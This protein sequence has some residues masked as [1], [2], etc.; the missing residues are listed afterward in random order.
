MN[1]LASIQR[2][3]SP[4]E[5]RFLHAAALPLVAGAFWASLYFQGV[6][7]TLYAAAFVLFAFWLG[8]ALW[9]A[10]AGHPI[11]VT[12][13]AASVAAFCL[14]LFLTLLWTRT[15]ALSALNAWWLST[16]GL[17]YFGYAFTERTGRFW[18]RLGA[19]VVTSV[20]LLC[21][22]A[23]VQAAAWGEAP[24]AMFL[25]INSFAALLNLV[26]LPLAG[27]LLARPF[28][29]RDLLLWFM[30]F[31]LVFTMFL[32]RG[33]GAFVGFALGLAVLAV[34]ARRAGRSPWGL[35]GVVGAAFAG[36]E[37]MLSGAALARL[38]T[39][40]APLAAGATRFV[41]W[42]GAWHLLWQAPWR[43]V[44]LGAFF[45]AY[46]PYRLPGDTSAGFYVHNDYLQIAIEAGLIGLFLLIGVLV[47]AT[48]TFVRGYARQSAQAVRLEAA[49]LFAGLLA[50]AV[51][52]L[53]DFNLYV[54]P[55]TLLAGLG[56]SRLDEL[57]GQ[58]RL[59][60]W[61]P[62]RFFS[63]GGLRAIIALGTVGA[64]AMASSVGL[65]QNDYRQA[66]R[67]AAEGRLV[68]ADRALGRAERRFPGLSNFWF[69]NADLL[70]HWADTLPM[71]DPARGRLAHLAWRD[72]AR[73]Q[74]L[75]PWQ[76][77]TFLIRA[78]LL[79]QERV[80]L[81]PGA[82]RAAL[83]AVYQALARDPRFYPARLFGARL[84][85]ASHQKLAAR[86]LLAAGRAYW[87]PQDAGALRDRAARHRRSGATT[88]AAP[89]QPHGAAPAAVPPSG[90]GL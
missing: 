74:Q 73:A 58:G 30:V 17:G 11:R 29:R 53:V 54:M 79:A 68:A 89:W 90:R 41:I 12:V 8:A 59:Y 48:A 18:P 9:S 3:S 84:L 57:A 13:L 25:N 46:P 66:F 10:P 34:L 50:V 51:H 26:S 23:I 44:G 39:L 60:V 64:V 65:A 83:H 5:G 85:R 21:G 33:R 16:L 81:G 67:R 70:R 2:P 14:W 27:F 40:R 43:G 15:P 63:V 52:S 72:L 78:E 6:H 56:L 88:P 80:W 20:A 28:H 37:I 77:Q 38:S 87:Y 47:A 49:G 55:I 62:G 42:R 32:T 86:A 24:T 36:A 31:L 22:Y 75:N 4:G 19:I 76:P 82:R 61:R 69:T 1:G 35:L 71:H 7:L 45:L